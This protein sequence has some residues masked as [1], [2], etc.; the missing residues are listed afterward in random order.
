MNQELIQRETTHDQQPHQPAPFPTG[1]Q[2]GPG[3]NVGSVAIEQERAIAQIQG[4][5]LLARKM[6][7]NANAAMREFEDACKIPEF[8]SVAFFSVP[9]GNNQRVEGESIRF[10]EEAARCWGNIYTYHKEL[11]RSDGKSEVVVGAW[12][13][14][15]GFHVE[16]QLTVV[17]VIDLQ[18]GSRRC[19]S[20]K[21]IDDLINNKAAKQRRGVILA[22][23]PKWFT[24]AGKKIAKLTVA[25]GTEKPLSQRIRDMA[26]AFGQ[27]GVTVDHLEAYLEHALDLTT[28]DEL[29]ELVGVYNALKEGAKPAEYFGEAMKTEK[30]NQTAAAIAAAGKAAG[31]GA[32]APAA[33]Q[34]SGEGAAGTGKAAATRKPTAARAAP[35]EDKAAPAGEQQQDAAPAEQQESKPAQNKGNPPEEQA[36]PAAKAVQASPAPGEQPDEDV[37]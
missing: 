7:R 34:A 31:K 13:L 28:I 5:M 10:A 19:R 1:R 23:L 4:E 36:A 14:Q 20:E 32:D 27:F 18:S 17:H 33:A 25:G 9:R 12:D 21:E 37:F 16:R 35:T 8:A 15:T 30:S 6:P 24:E 26:T 11:S 3:V 2:L 22:V 29:A